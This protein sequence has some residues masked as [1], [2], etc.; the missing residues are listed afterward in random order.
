MEVGHGASSRSVIFRRVLWFFPFV[1][2]VLVP[3]LTPIFSRL[4]RRQQHLEH[5]AW[6]RYDTL[7]RLDTKLN[8]YQG[9]HNTLDALVEA[10]RTP[11]R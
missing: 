10:L 3:F 7:D 1:S 4:A 2:S 8:W 9:Q 6:E 11:E 5:R